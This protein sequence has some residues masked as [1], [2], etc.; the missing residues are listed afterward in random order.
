[1]KPVAW[2]ENMTQQ[3]NIYLNTLRE[4]GRINMFGATPYLMDRF[5]LTRK[6]ASIAL[7]AWMES[8]KQEKAK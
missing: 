5:D 4:S 6:Q 2:R 7:I 8:Y 3:I 1:M